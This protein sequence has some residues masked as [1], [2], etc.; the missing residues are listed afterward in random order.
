MFKKLSTLVIKYPWYFI[1]GWVVFAAA[2]MLTA[3][4]LI[5][6]TSS[7]SGAGLSSSYQS[8]QA[9][10]TASKYFPTATDG[11][12]SLAISNTDGQVLST[13][14]QQINR[15]WSDKQNNFGLSPAEL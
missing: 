12:G 3:P 14:N 2:V 8:V 6:Y 9:S 15:H 13:A 1:L 5:D 10:N 11:S 4:K 7:S